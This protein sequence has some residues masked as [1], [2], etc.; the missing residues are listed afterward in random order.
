MERGQ[1]KNQQAEGGLGEK[2]RRRKVGEGAEG[3]GGVAVNFVLI[4]AH[5]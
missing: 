2:K 4:D 1:I 3:W 5:L